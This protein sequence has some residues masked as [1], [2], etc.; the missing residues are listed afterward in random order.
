MS[1]YV[2]GSYTGMT[3]AELKLLK[4]MKTTTD[5]LKAFLDKKFAELAP[6]GA[7][8]PLE[9]G[10]LQ[11]SRLM[12]S[13]SSNSAAVLTN[14]AASDRGAASVYRAYRDGE[15]ILMANAAK[16]TAASEKLA[17][18]RADM[19]WGLVGA[20]G[21]GIAATGSKSILGSFGSKIANLLPK[22]SVYSQ[23]YAQAYSDMAGGASAAKSGIFGGAL[24]WGGR[25]AA[26]GALV[27]GMSMYGG[28]ELPGA[29]TAETGGE[30]LKSVWPAG[31]AAGHGMFIGEE[32]SQAANMAFYTATQAKSRAAMGLAHEAAV[33]NIGFQEVAIAGAEKLGTT[34]VQIDAYKEYLRVSREVVAAQ[35]AQLEF[36]DIA[37]PKIKE[38]ED[39][40]DRTTKTLES[41]K[42]KYAELQKEQSA[43]PGQISDYGAKRFGVGATIGG[44]TVGSELGGMEQM[45]MLQK[46]MLTAKKAQLESPD[47]YGQYKQMSATERLA[48]LQAGV[49]L[50]SANLGYVSAAEGTAA[51]DRALVAV[52][53]LRAEE[54]MRSATADLQI[55]QE[56]QRAAASDTAGAAYEEASRK[57][58]IASIDMQLSYGDMHKQ[59][60]FFIM[61]HEDMADKVPATVKTVEESIKGLWKRQKELDDEIPNMARKMDESQDS[62]DAYKA[63]LRDLN[64]NGV[65][66]L[67]RG[68]E[69]L[70]RN[71]RDIQ[72]GGPNFRNFESDRMSI[73]YSL[74]E[75]S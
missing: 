70:K 69:D 32:S 35:K 61:K 20:G 36:Y 16:F 23:S 18:N 57:L 46:E 6:K 27:G 25:V 66:Y 1:E 50:A 38:Y 75:N 4:N 58:Q 21:G 17:A 5:P 62:I 63:F 15:R 31:Y 72:N 45:W 14:T 10:R 54:Q 24:K 7:V 49:G 55:E 33:K 39:R 2:W 26:L 60:E 30:I 67:N 47:V 29:G 42:D 74:S 51:K 8:T 3:D 11:S 9:L 37:K 59:V 64:D 44:V 13:V 34:Q 22:R 41:Q 19:A 56:K 12:G 65:A 71:L 48:G 68:L 53:K 40:L 28:S 52:Q 43:I 73:D